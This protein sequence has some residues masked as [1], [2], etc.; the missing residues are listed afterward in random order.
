MS[1]NGTSMKSF[2]TI[3]VGQL[4][5]ILGSGLT[6]FA[7]GIWVLQRTQYQSTCLA[8]PPLDCA[9]VFWRLELA[10]W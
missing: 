9:H 6:A 3:W 8:R 4:V 10:S 2:T 7:L 5:S 1:E